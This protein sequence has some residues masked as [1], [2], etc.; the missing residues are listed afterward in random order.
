MIITQELK[1]M[2]NK[3]LKEAFLTSLSILVNPV[4]SELIESCTNLEETMIM[5]KIHDAIAQ[6]AIRAFEIAYL[7]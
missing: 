2:A 1:N 7:K 3:F 5:L 6:V 4:I